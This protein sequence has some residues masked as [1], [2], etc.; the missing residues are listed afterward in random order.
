MHYHKALGQKAGLSVAQI[1]DLARFEHSDAYS[2]Q[3]KDV[4]RFAEQWTR[5]GKVS[6]DVIE[7]LKASLSPAHLV[8][9]AATVSQ[10]NLTSRF[11]NTF[12]V[13]LP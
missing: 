2:S 7:R 3:E 8:L 13:E 12:G 9:L 1:N 11:N 4:L 10:A 6:T 5:N